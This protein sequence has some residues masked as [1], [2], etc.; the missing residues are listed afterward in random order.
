MRV[1][2]RMALGL[3]VVALAIT[4][5]P[6]APAQ[7]ATGTA[8]D[9]TGIAATITELT[10]KYSDA[11]EQNNTALIDSLVA[12]D[13]WMVLPDGRR[14]NRSEWSATV[15]GQQGKFRATKYDVLQTTVRVHG[16]DVAVVVSTQDM[17]GTTHGGLKLDHQRRVGTV[18]VNRDGRW[19][20]V[21]RVIT[22]IAEAGR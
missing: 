8:P 10:Q 15:S 5:I 22:P 16:N 2:P 17:E 1:L 7:Q 11:L 9:S 19:Q 14:L 6:N 18:W 20:I 13:A 3:A 21:S 4:I 12:S